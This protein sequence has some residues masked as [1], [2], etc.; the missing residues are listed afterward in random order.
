MWG[1][2]LSGSM[3][4]AGGVGGLLAV[5][6]WANGAHFAAYDG[7]G[8]VVAMVK[9]A[10]GTI[11]A[12]YEYGP[13]AEPIRVTGPMGKTNP[14]RF[15]SKYTD[16]ESDFLYYGHR[17]YNPSTGRWLNRDPI[18]ESDGPN[19]YAFLRNDGLNKIDFLGRDGS[20]IGGIY[21]SCCSGPR[22]PVP[23]GYNCSCCSYTMVQKGL[24]KLKDRFNMAKKYLD[25]NGV[26]PDADEEYPKGISCY[27]SAEVIIKFMKKTPACWICFM[28]ERGPWLIGMYSQNAIVC[29]ST[30]KGIGSQAVIFDWFRKKPAG[31]NYDWFT[32]QYPTTI[33][34]YPDRS[35]SNYNDCNEKDEQWNP[36]YS[37]FHYWVS[38]K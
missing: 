27:D 21:A 16:D 2:D 31:Q 20:S 24:Q 25:D 34:S 17:Y 30:G 14:I 12:Q 5:N 33:A 35:Y 13:F 11:S 32:L 6:D 7:N 4:G 23:A 28:E 19:I 38:R 22:W 3:Q 15:S 10:D 37:L 1:L 26:I 36:D 29:F 9:A 18:G 8:N